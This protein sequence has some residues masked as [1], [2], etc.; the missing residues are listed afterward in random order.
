M[1]RRLFVVLSQSPT[2]NAARR[3]LE[4]ELVTQL[5]MESG[6][7]MNVVPHLA[8]LPADATGMLCLEGI[9]GHM[10]LASWLTDGEARAHLDRYGIQGRQGV[11]RLADPE[12]VAEALEGNGRQTA[13]GRAIYLLNLNRHTETDALLAEIRRIR[14]DQSVQTFQLGGIGTSPL[15]LASPSSAASPSPATQPIPRPGTSSPPTS[16]S[17]LT[18]AS[19]SASN[20]TAAST[21]GVSSAPTSSSTATPKP[22]SSVADSGTTSDWD[23]EDARREAEAERLVD[24]L[25]ELDI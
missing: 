4:E 25:D 22:S 9:T 3:Q 6:I 18:S 11:T 24:Q 20:S 12:E 16:P 5:L 1:A 7:E 8:D 2:S 15:P 23:R 17:S 19:A 14:D 10:V 13:G 21:S